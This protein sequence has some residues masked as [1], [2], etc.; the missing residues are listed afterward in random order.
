M[1]F[2]NLYTLGDNADYRKNSILSNIKTNKGHIYRYVV[3]CV[4]Y[5]T[6]NKHKNALDIRKLPSWIEKKIKSHDR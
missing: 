4:Q 2:R 6:L 1:P 3:I 5:F